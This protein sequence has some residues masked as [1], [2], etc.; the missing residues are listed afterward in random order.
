MHWFNWI[1]MTPWA[2]VVLGAIGLIP[3]LYLL[4]AAADFIEWRASRHSG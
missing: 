1:G 4:G 2:I 3:S